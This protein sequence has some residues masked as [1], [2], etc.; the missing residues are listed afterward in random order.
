MI[1]LNLMKQVSDLADWFMTFPTKLVEAVM[2]PRKAYLAEKE[3]IAKLNE[4]AALREIGQHVTTL[5]IFKG[6]IYQWINRLQAQESAEEADY[7]RDMFLWAADALN[8]VEEILR[9]TP[10]SNL[11]LA[12]EAASKV[13]EGKRTYQS[14]AKLSDGDILG[15]RGLIDIVAAMDSMIDNGSFLVRLADHH[16]QELEGKHVK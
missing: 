2:A 11:T 1:D 6:N 12:S 7:V 13:A 3:N 8:S 4:M 5:Y 16:T 15:D 14:L 10:L 9:R